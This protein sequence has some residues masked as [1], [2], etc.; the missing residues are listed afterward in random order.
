MPQRFESHSLKS[1]GDSF[2]EPRPIPCHGPAC[3]NSDD[4]PV[5]LSPTERRPHLPDEWIGR[6][7]TERSPG[8]G[9]QFRLGELEHRQRPGWPLQIDRPPEL[10]IPHFITVL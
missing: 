10:G 4:G 3:E 8:S 9:M 2:S 1:I 5:P 6:S 7:L